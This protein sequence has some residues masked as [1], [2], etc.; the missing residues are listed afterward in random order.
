MQNNNESTAY[1]RFLNGAYSYDE[2]ESFFSGIEDPACKQ[3]VEKMAVEIWEETAI[4]SSCTPSEKERYKQ[5]ARSLLKRISTRNGLPLKRI[6]QAV[7]SA[8]AVIAIT[9]S[10]FHL[11]NRANDAGITYTEIHASSGEKKQFLLPDGS[12]V[13]LNACSQLRYPVEFSDSPRQRSVILKGE[14]YFDV[15]GDAAKP[16]IVTAEH[17]NVHVLGTAFNVKSYETDDLVGVNVERGKVKI[18]M[19]G[20]S[21]QLTAHERIT[22]NTVS[23]DFN[24]QRDYGEAAVWRKGWLRFNHT[25]IRDVARELERVYSCRIVFREGQE[26]DN[27]ISGEHDNQSLESVLRSLEFASGITF[28]KENNQ[29]VLYKK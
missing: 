14:A 11:L 21:V 5:E 19:Q 15:A 17:F 16:F 18:E 8:A 2:A 26:F 28:K 27:L 9:L 29:I 22:V 10:L 3:A 25:P 4:G 24:K 12:T 20:A 6:L 13:V 1:K 23:G 7:G